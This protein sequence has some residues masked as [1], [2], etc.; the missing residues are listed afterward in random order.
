MKARTT[1]PLPH[2]M[3]QHPRRSPRTPFHKGEEK[4]VAKRAY[5]LNHIAKK[6]YNTM[7]ANVNL[8]TRT[9]TRAQALKRWFW[10]LLSSKLVRQTQTSRAFAIRSH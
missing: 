8:E 3:P 7:E 6:L 1:L 9:S 4:I 5:A 10:T 2:M